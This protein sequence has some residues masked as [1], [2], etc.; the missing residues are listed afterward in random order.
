MVSSKLS[1]ELLLPIL[2]NELL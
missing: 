1:T 2:V